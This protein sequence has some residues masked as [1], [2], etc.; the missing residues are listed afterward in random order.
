MSA[1]K[2]AIMSIKTPP[3]H[4][5]LVAFGSNQGDSERLL[6]QVVN[7]LRSERWIFDFQSSRGYWTCPVD[8]EVGARDFLNAVF[9]WKVSEK[10]FPEE[11]LA[12]LL[13]LEKDFGRKRIPGIGSRSV[14]L[15][16]LLF[17]GECRNQQPYMIL[18]HPRM[19]QRRFVLLPAAE[20]AGEWIHPTEKKTL[21]ELLSRCP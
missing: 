14:D 9:R 3:Q 11:V 2:I 8:C 6:A 15:D 20:I 13:Q 17:D 10:M 16:L 12:F 4:D 18:P 5:V 19:H 1:T 21:Q 7:V